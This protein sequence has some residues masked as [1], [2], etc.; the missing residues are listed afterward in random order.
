MEKLPID[1]ALRWCEVNHSWFEPCCRIP[2]S[3]P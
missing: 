2:R 1:A 3:L